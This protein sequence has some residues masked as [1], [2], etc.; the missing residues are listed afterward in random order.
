MFYVHVFSLFI[1][2]SSS[3]DL[4]IIVSEMQIIKNDNNSQ[5]VRKS[6]ILNVNEIKNIIYIYIYIYILE[7]PVK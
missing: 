1:S 5:V 2:R 3:L 4:V 7:G 6:K